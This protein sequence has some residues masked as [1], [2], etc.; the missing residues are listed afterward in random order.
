MEVMIFVKNKYRFLL[1][2]CTFLLLTTNC[3]ADP[4]SGLCDGNEG[5]PD[6]CPLDTWVIVLVAIVGIFA[7]IHLHRKQ[8]SL[9]A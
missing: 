8:R 7:A 6:G 4:G 9:Q 1:G 2:V 5:G 3:F